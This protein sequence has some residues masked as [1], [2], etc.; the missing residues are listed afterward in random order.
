[1]KGLNPMAIISAVY[2]TK[3]PKRVKRVLS[4]GNT[5]FLKV[6]LLGRAKTLV[7]QFGGPGA[8]WRNV[9]ASRKGTAEKGGYYYLVSDI[10]FVAGVQSANAEVAEEVTEEAAA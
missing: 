2:Q 6:V 8:T 5:T 1:M 7:D 10:G 3:S 9:T 4:N